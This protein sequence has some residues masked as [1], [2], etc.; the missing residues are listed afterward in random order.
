MDGSHNDLR[1]PSTFMSEL[2]K[3]ETVK[4]CKK[5]K[6]VTQLSWEFEAV[7]AEPRELLRQ[8][9][10]R[11]YSKSWIHKSVVFDELFDKKTSAACVSW[12]NV[13]NIQ[14]DVLKIPHGFYTLWI[15]YLDMIVLIE[16]GDMSICSGP[17]LK[18]SPYDTFDTV[19][20][21]FVVRPW[22]SH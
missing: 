18:Q 4:E 21:R 9:P 16:V 10:F 5:S 20:A 1:N 2:M 22:E 8:C 19:Q 15:V 12:Y 3:Y 6:S 13:S 11:K 14:Y 7:S 17:G